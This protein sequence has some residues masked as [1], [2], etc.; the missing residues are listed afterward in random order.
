M[1]ELAWVQDEISE[2]ERET[3]EELYYMGAGDIA[4]LKAVLEL[5]WVQDEISETEYD[6]IYW[7]EVL[8]YEDPEAAGAVIAMPFLA[9]LEYDDVLAIRGMRSLAYDGLLSAMT[10]TP[11]WGSG[12]T[13]AQTTL[14]AAAGTLNDGQEVARMMN[15]GYASV[16]TAS[17]QT[18][19]TPNL[20]VSII[21]TGTPSQPWTAGYVSAAVQFVEQTMQ[22]PLP[23]SHVIVVLNDSAVTD[24]FAGTNHGQAFSFRPQYEAK[25]RPYDRYIFQAG[26][27]HEVAHYFWRGNEAWINEGLANTFEYMHGVGEGISP[28]LLENRRRECEVHDLES[29]ANYNPAKGDPQFRCNYYL[30]QLLFQELLENMGD[31]EFPRRLGEFY[32]LSLAGQ[33]EQQTP[34]IAEV[35]QAFYD[36]VEIVEKHW[37]GKMNAPE[38]RPYDDIGG[39]TSHDL[40][41]WDQY[42]THVG[43]S[44]TFSG[45]VIGEA[46]L[47]SETIE[48]AR[49]GGYQ[50]FTLR[51]ADGYDYFGSIFPPFDDDW[52][53]V[54]ETPGSTVALEYEVDEGKFR[55]KFQLRQGRLDPSNYVVVVLG[56]PDGSRT[57]F[58]REE[59]D[60]LGFARIRVVE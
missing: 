7:L 42:P 23:V 32:R 14:V 10:G 8:A 52:H 58:V 2:R 53:W 48:Q 59:I 28:G 16:E 18:D 47:S 27:V 3:I 9:T 17:Y 30:G 54:S 15:P 34:G 35:R 31:T 36:Q 44:V 56:F 12:F 50:N 43:D 55:V 22:L 25:Q 1:L 33:E 6:A 11:A 37:S 19:L 20:K 24:D 13:D 45:T 39:I 38:N 60:T 40:I 4:N 49:K 5:A 57:P 26:I 46:T 41:Q 51:T 29:L 21:R